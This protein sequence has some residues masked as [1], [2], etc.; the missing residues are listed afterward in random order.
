MRL[1]LSKRSTSSHRDDCAFTILELLIVMAISSVLIAIV[2]PSLS[3]A[4][5]TANI[6]RCWRFPDDTPG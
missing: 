6:S 1:R 5:E 3:A 2:L 4:R